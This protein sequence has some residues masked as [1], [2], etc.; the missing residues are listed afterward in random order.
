MEP[1]DRNDFTR[2]VRHLIKAIPPGKVATYGQIALM[3]G[4]PRHV[5]G[6]V[7]ILHS[8]SRSHDLPWHR[9]VNARGRISLP[10]GNGFE[11]QQSR[12]LS[13]GIVFGQGDRI[14][15]RTFQWDPLHMGEKE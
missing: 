5:R 9:V 3:A 6:V 13:E 12:L 7:W 10:P 8:S 1:D 11:E 15:L 2:R 14:D 4:N